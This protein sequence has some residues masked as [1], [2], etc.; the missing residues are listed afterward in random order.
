MSW[1]NE[2]LAPRSPKCSKHLLQDFLPAWSHEMARDGSRRSSGACCMRKPSNEESEASCR[3]RALPILLYPAAANA[4]QFITI[5]GP[6]GTFGD[7][8]AISSV[9]GNA[10][11]CSFI[12]SFN[13]DT[14]TGLT[15]ARVDISSI[16]TSGLLTNIDFRTVMLNG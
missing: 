16:A 7:D 6:C 2:R 14:P 1:L 3:R 4:A 8:R 15:F 5:T 12:R 10:G 9:S 13:F 11:L